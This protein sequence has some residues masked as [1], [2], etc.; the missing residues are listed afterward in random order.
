MAG[1]LPGVESARRR[2]FH[3]NGGWSDSPL[4]YG[5]GSTRRFYM[6]NCDSNLTSSSSLVSTTYCQSKIPLSVS[7]SVIYLD[8]CTHQ[9]CVCDSVNIYNFTYL[10]RFLK[11]QIIIFRNLK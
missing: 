7:L 10:T 2:R 11:I 6:S 5:Y 1:M 8:F 4:T 9:T 3:G